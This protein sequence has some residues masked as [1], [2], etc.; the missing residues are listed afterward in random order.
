MRAMTL[1]RRLLGVTGLRVIGMWFFFE[2]DLAV[3]VAPS[4]RK[5]RCGQCG[6]RGPVHDYQPFRW[7]RHAVWGATAVKLGYAPRR[8]ACRR[9]G[10][11]VERL[12]WADPDSRFTYAFEEWVAYLAQVTDKTQVTK[13]AGIAWRTVSSIVGRVVDRRLSPDRFTGLVRIGIDEFSYRGQHRYVTVVVDHDRQ[14]VVWSA[15][16]KSGE[17][18]RQ[19]FELLTAE[20]RATIE[21]A[22]MDLAAS[23]RK[24]VAESL[25]HVEIVFDRFHVQRLASNALDEVRRA[26]VRELGGSELGAAIKNT[27]WVLLRR[28]EDLTHSQRERLSEVQRSNQPLYRA[29]LLK[30]TL[31][32]ALSYKQPKRAK[33]ALESWISWGVRSRLKPFIRVARTIRKHLPGILAYVRHRVT[34]GLVEGINNKLR[35]VTRRAFGF[36]SAEALIGMLYLTCGGIVLNPPLPGPTP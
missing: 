9:C 11:R 36:H 16:G 12:A 23:Y 2:G 14:R 3:E 5:A 33:E 30:E 25:P 22:T 28:P 19:F 7:W 15:E 26:L 10:V 34:N 8:V 31:A 6:R 24:A 21:L 20:Q 27:R 17:T 35:M 1:L 4:R 29:Y 13:L 18:L 32:S